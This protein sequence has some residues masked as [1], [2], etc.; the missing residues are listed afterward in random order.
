MKTCRNVLLS[1]IKICEFLYYVHV[2]MTGDWW[3]LSDGAT[4]NDEYI[5]WRKYLEYTFLYV[6]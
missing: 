4:A 2:K 3:L 6:A 5:S 1:S